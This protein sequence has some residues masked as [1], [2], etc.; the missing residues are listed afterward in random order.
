MKSTLG[1][2][3]CFLVLGFFLIASAGRAQNAQADKPSFSPAAV[4]VNWQQRTT[5]QPRR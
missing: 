4:T 5:I 3:F 2:L 1:T